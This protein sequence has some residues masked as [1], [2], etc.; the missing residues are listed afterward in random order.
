MHFD[1]YA[2]EDVTL[3][4]RTPDGLEVTNLLGMESLVSIKKS[5]STGKR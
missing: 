1:H 3:I 5:S 2:I 4:D